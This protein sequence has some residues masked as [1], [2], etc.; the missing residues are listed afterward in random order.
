MLLKLKILNS[1]NKQQL[2]NIR[3]ISV[4]LFL[5]S[6]TLLVLKLERSNSFNEEQWVNIYDISVNFWY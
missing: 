3:S 6:A 4:T 2:K 1:S 5:L